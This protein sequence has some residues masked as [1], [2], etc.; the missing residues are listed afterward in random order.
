VTSNQNQRLD[1]EPLYDV[2]PETAVGI[3]VFY[4]DHTLET[5]GRRGAGWFWWPRRGYSPDDS[6]I[7]PF[8]TRGIGAS[9]HI[10]LLP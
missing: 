9:Q 5:F 6:T 8:A 1:R 4:S 3:E 10:D 2:D 7:G